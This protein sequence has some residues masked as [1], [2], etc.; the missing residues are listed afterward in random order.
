M[1]E[2]GLGTNPL[3]SDDFLNMSDSQYVGEFARFGALG[4]NIHLKM[5]GGGRNGCFSAVF[6]LRCKVSS[7]GR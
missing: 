2:N 7:D 4:T 5:A 6:P 1:V 3:T